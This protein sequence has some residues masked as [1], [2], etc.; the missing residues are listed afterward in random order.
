ML[1]AW[2]L[3]DLSDCVH[4]SHAAGSLVIT[5]NAHSKHQIITHVNNTGNAAQDE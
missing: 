5:Q 4:K 2:C 1:N 3:H